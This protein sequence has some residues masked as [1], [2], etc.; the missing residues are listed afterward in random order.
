MV[1]SVG[2]VAELGEGSG[3]LLES[4]RC[5]LDSEGVAVLCRARR[6]SLLSSVGCRGV[7]WAFWCSGSG[8]E[9]GDRLRELSR[10]S[11]CSQKGVWWSSASRIL[12]GFIGCSRVK[13]ESQDA[14]SSRGQLEVT[15]REKGRGLR[16][17]EVAGAWATKSLLKP[18]FWAGGSLCV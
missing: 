2:V 18:R 3:V 11:G 4:A 12:F 5:V 8:G 6:W 16:S 15:G 14:Q 9:V 13:V 10:G 1:S 17:G 7:V